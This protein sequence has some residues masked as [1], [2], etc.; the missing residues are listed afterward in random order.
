MPGSAECGVIGVAGAGVVGP[1]LGGGTELVDPPRLTIGDDII[2]CCCSD[3][4]YH[5]FVEIDCYLKGVSLIKLTGVC[6][7]IIL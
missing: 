5:W 1:I 4:Y 6:G 3:I 2:V 7:C